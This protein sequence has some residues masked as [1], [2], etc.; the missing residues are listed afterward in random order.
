MEKHGQRFLKTPER[1]DEEVSSLIS[2]ASWI[3]EEKDR[4]HRLISLWEK[5][6]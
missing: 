3:L 5:Y 2:L 1:I 4:G 6:L